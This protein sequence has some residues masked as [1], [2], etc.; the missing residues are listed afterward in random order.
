[1]SFIW[2]KDKNYIAFFYFFKFIQ[3]EIIRS[4][5]FVQE[6]INIFFFLNFLDSFGLKSITY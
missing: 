1:M 2:G 4:I 3:I 5:G 6:K